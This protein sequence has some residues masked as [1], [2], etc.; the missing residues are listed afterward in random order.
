[1]RTCEESE[2]GEKEQYFRYSLLREIPNVVEFVFL[3]IKV[4]STQVV[5]I[6]DASFIDRG[7]NID[8]KKIYSI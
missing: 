8:D 4:Y 5:A 3:L 2:W 1:M 6:L 7:A